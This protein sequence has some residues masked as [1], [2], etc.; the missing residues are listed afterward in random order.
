M[1]FYSVHYENMPMQYTEMFFSCKNK[2]SIG[3]FL[4]FFK[5]MLKTLI[6]GT[7]TALVRWF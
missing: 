3:K 4:I 6:V 7:H 1:D 2:N 5:F